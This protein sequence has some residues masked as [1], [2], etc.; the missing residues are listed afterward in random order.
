MTV[1]ESLRQMLPE[2]SKSECRAAD[3][4]L[5]YPNDVRRTTCES[6]AESSGS[7]RSAVIRLCQKLGFRGYSEF[8][9]ALRA[10]PAVPDA[11]GRTTLQIY[12]DELQRMESLYASEPLASLAKDLLRAN[13][14][15]A[16]GQLHSGM[17]A[18]QLAF[19][20]NRF[21]LDC[22]ALSDVTLMEGYQS[23]LKQGDVVVIF[24]ISG[25]NTYRDVVIPYR[26]NG[27]RVALVTMTSQAPISKL[28][29]DVF[30]L[31]RISHA[32]TGYLLDDEITFFTFIELLIEA[33]HKNTSQA[34][35]GQ[36]L[37]VTE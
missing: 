12:L 21:G 1:L 23:V 14:I 9:Y 20:L 28:V 26:Q 36:G 22:N 32:S 18:Q 17:A 33:M 7:S 19:R 11:S 30:L 25:Q 34:N 2:L 5:R 31:P 35:K 16:L 15:L 3:Y 6:I 8:R 27:V 4:L 10:E 13:H 37:P 29:N 24:S